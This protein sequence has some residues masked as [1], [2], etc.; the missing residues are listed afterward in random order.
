MHDTITYSQ[1][2]TTYDALGGVAEITQPDGART[3]TEYQGRR[4]AVLDAN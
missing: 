1:N 4:T 3:L 2:V